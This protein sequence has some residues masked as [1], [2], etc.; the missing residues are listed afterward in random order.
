MGTFPHRQPRGLRDGRGKSAPLLLSNSRIFFFYAAHNSI[1]VILSHWRGPEN[2]PGWCVSPL[3]SEA[4]QKSYPKNVILR[5]ADFNGTAGLIGNQWWQIFLRLPF[6]LLESIRMLR[7]T[8][9][10]ILTAAL[11]SA[12][13]EGEYGS[14][15]L[16]RRN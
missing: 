12:H 9:Q 1:G 5:T 6:G 4:E 8:F 3:G 14:K 10:N 11:V 7:N 16:Q 15:E 13:F 2:P